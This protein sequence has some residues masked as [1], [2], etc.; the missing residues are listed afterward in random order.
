MSLVSAWTGRTACALQ[1]AFRDSNES[2]AARLGIGVRTVADWHQKPSVKPRSTMQQVLDTAFEH[3]SQSVKSR[4]AQL[5]A[6]VSDSPSTVLSV[7][8]D[9]VTHD[10]TEAAERARAVA[11]AKQRLSTDTNIGE[12]LEWLDRY[13]GWE[14]GTARRKVAARLAE[15]DLGHL[16]DRGHRRGR[17]R[18]RQLAQSLRGYY[19]GN[20]EGY[21]TYTARYDNEYAVT[22]ILTRADWL[23]LECQLTPENDRLALTRSAT[24]NNGTP[25]ELTAEQAVNR[26]AETLATGTRLTNTPLY[27]LTEIDVRKGLIAGTVGLVPFARYALTMDLL[28]AEAVDVVAGGYAP[29]PGTMPL[30]DR[31]LPGL[32]SVVNVADRLCC[33][34]ND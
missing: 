12:A 29:Q 30:R 7:E 1:E 32:T 5:V 24:D 19:Q 11:G 23:D 13:V 14:P 4:F 15:L 18:Q 27:Q 25:D 3:A 8:H 21:G 33:G 10:D 22:S 26:L 20:V 28:E 6:G 2:F 34:G 17:V 16:Q 31:Y 9:S